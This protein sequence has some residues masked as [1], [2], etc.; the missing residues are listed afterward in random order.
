MSDRGNDAD[1]H[2]LSFGDADLLWVLAMLQSAEAEAVAMCTPDARRT[3]A[4]IAEKRAEIAARIPFP[5]ATPE[6]PYTWYTV[7]TAVQ[8][9]RRYAVRIRRRGWG[10]APDIVVAVDG[11]DHL[12][13]RACPEAE[14]HLPAIEEILTRLAP[15]AARREDGV[16]AT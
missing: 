11:S 6:M 2:G 1:P 9:C 16:A 15:V 3:R 14:Q 4:R 7:V 13:A 10:S 5:I 12:L 8:T